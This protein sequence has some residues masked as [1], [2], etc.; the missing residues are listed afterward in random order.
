MKMQ[1]TQLSFSAVAD[2]FQR[3]IAHL[4]APGCGYRL[5][6]IPS[7]AP[8]RP[9]SASYTRTSPGWRVGRLVLVL[10]ICL[11]TLS[12]VP[13]WA[14]QPTL[15]SGVPNIFDPDV[16]E[17]LELLGVTNLRG[18][19]DFPMVMLINTDE[20]TSEALLCK[21]NDF[22]ATDLTLISY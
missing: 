22:Q 19:P 20:D 3:A 12:S 2:F 10:G 8:Y 1:Y 9:S 5:A 11:L 4:T 14:G 7:M 18:N 13:A 21:G 16:R 15:P 17:H 6:P